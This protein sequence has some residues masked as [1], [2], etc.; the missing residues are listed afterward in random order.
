MRPTD[1]PYVSLQEAADYLSK[2]Q[3]EETTVRDIIYL[4]EI[5]K[6]PIGAF[7]FRRAE[8]KPGLHHF[9]P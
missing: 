6:L 1:N 7:R 2:Q 3:G 9:H 4:G 8:I 5:G